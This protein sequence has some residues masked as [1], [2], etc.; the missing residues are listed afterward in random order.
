MNINRKL[1]VK[2][3]TDHV[4][5]LTGRV[6]DHVE[7]N[8]WVEKVL[9]FAQPCLT[10]RSLSTKTYP[11]SRGGYGVVIFDKQNHKG[12]FLPGNSDHWVA[13]TFPED[14]YHG[15]ERRLEE[16]QFG[17]DVIATAIAIRIKAGMKLPVGFPKKR[18]RV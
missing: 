7:R 3:P 13:V 15:A 18:V 14:A 8:P 16:F 12:K 10:E 2:V 9:G 17:A 11:E 6:L 1:T 4:G 5:V